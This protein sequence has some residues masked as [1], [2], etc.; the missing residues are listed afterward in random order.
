MPTI[1][2]PELHP[3]QQ[4]I[5]DHPARFKI[6]CCGRRFGKTTLALFLMS[7]HLLNAHRVAYFAPT[8]GMSGEVWRDMQRLMRPIIQHRS[9]HE[10]RLD[11]IT[12]GTLDIWTTYNET[13]RGRSYHF[14]VVDEAALIPSADVWNAAIRPL[15]TDTQGSAL[16]ASTPRGRNWFFELYG[17]GA[18]PTI[19][20]YQSWTHPTAHNPHIP[21]AEIEATRHT[22]PERVF[23]QE[24]LA[25]FLSDGSAVFPNLSGVTTAQPTAPTPGHTY[26]F[27]VDWGRDNDFTAV[28]VLDATTNTQVKL[29]RMTSLSYTSQRQRI[30]DLYKQYRPKAILAESNSIGTV[31]IEDLQSAGLPVRPFT[32]TNRSKAAIIDAL[33][34][35]IEQNQITLLNDEILKHEMHA[36]QS[37][38]TPSGLYTYN[39]PPGIHD[40][41]VIATAL[42]YHAAHA[43]NRISIDFA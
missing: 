8:Y 16:F 2:L 35:A 18:E 12:G 11:L 24:Y 10:H 21:A 4:T 22:L 36:Y 3:H 39:A 20:E 40:D 19:H 41:T 1:K 29:Y 42:S 5:A 27:G 13:A 31:N 26:V 15:L 28:S 38:R 6:L 25:E 32:T 37:E 14:V 17:L 34:L 7:K 9:N 43:R 33:A 23:K 30:I